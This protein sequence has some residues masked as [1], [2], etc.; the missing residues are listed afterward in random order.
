MERVYQYYRRP[1]HLFPYDVRYDPSDVAFC[2]RRADGSIRFRLITEPGFTEA[3]LARLDGSGTTMNR[4]A[5]DRRFLYWEAT[6]EPAGSTLE[7]SFALRFGSDQPVY[8]VP[9]GITN[10]AE[11]LDYWGLDV[12]QTQHVE[13]PQWARGAVIYQIFPDR[14]ASGDPTL[15][16]PDADPWGSPPHSRRFQGGDLR[17]IAQKAD[18]LADL[19]IDAVYLNPVFRSLSVHRYDAVDYYEVDQRLGG[20]AA[21]AETVE[22]LHARDIK[23]I[24]DASFN[25]CHPHFFAFQD[26]IANGPASEYWDWFDVHSYPLTVQIRPR[27][28]RELYGERAEH[29]LD[30]QVNTI[31]AAGLTLVESDD[32]GPP[33]EPSY[34][35][36]YRVP[37]MPRLVLTNPATR[38]YFLEVATH[39]ITDYDIDGWRM[40]VARYIDHD[41]WGDFRRAVKSVDPEVYLIAEIMGDAMPWLQGDQFDATMNY[42]FRELAVDFFAEPTIDAGRFVDG[43][44]RMHARYAPEI[45]LASQNLIGSHDTER[46]LTRAGGDARR[47]SLAVFTQMTVPGAPGLYYGDEVGM[48]GGSD[49][50]SR[51]AFPWHDAASWNRD[52]LTQA[53]TLGR[54]RS[55]HPALR[56]GAFEVVYL[57]RDAFAFTRTNADERLLVIVNRADEVLHCFIPVTTDRVDILYG[58]GEVS[59]EPLDLRVADVPPWSGLIASI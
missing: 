57:G 19:R 3:V 12:A 8:L 37:T 25:H 32:D 27:A 13:V 41:F 14:F 58:A 50:G 48:T 10:A 43:L 30:Y 21:L 9:S 4:Y 22:A 15:T 11:R 28:A 1:G 34:A 49:P 54:L 56:N 46:F 26:M 18:Y 24:L 53:R 31:K 2:E 45:V 33:V 16:P 20:N 44:I 59:P 38:Q 5:E 51:G 7:Y 36:W 55:D 40:D 39:W 35:S 42:Q 6:V 17:G 29:F 23:V 52:L 47:L